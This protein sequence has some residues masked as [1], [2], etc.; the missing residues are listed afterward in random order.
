MS[1]E[2]GYAVIDAAEVPLSEMFGYASTPFFYARKSRIHNGI[3]TLPPC[4]KR[5]QADLIKKHEEEKRTASTLM[6]TN[7]PLSKEHL[8]LLTQKEHSSGGSW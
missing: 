4:S 3:L 7:T 6:N 1:E 8:S 2:D 5:V